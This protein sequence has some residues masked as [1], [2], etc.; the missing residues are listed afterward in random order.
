[1]MTTIND[2][3]GITAFLNGEPGL[4][5]P[6]QK[7]YDAFTK[8]G[9]EAVIVDDLWVDPTPLKDLWKYE[10]LVLFTTGLLPENFRPLLKIFNGSGYVPKR[11]I[12]LTE[13]TA[14]FFVDLARDLKKLGTKFYFVDF[15]SF[16]N[17]V[18]IP[19]I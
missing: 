6:D 16:K 4:H 9:L 3:T 8:A 11:V 1:M 7:L 14:L 12:F 15:L 2:F 10:N 18:E 5:D 19:W 13:T 17:L